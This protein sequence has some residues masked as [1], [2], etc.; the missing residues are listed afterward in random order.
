MNHNKI[1]PETDP[2][3]T[4][5]GIR[6]PTFSPWRAKRERVGGWCPATQRAFIAELTRTGCPAE[7]AKAVGR[8][9]RS[10]YMLRDKPGAESF[11]AAWDTAKASAGDAAQA[12]AVSR[13]LHGEIVPIYRKG[14][15]WGFRVQHNDRMLMAALKAGGASDAALAAH[16]KTL[17]RWEVQLRRMQIGL[18][19]GELQGKALDEA[20]EDHRVWS[21]EI[22]RE[23]RR[24]RNAEIRAAVRK[25][26]AR[27][28]PPEPRIRGL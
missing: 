28:A 8:S 1:P 17:E 15:F 23:Q 20:E 2:T 24:Q 14:Q 4:P 10:A 21:R 7:A 9:K 6:I 19:L 13:A 3:H 25:G 12:V 22:E 18:E 26:M 27:E 5:E 16:R 11:A